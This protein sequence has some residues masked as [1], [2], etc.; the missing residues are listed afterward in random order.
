MAGSRIK[1]IT[2]EIGG[3]ATKLEKALEGVNKKVTQTSSDLKDLN[4]LLKFDPGNVELLKQKQE[5]LKKA[6]EATKERLEEEKKALAQLKEGD[7]TDEVKRNAELLERQIQDDEIALKNLKKEMKD[8]GSV[9]QQQIKAAGEKMQELGGNISKVGQGIAD[10]GTGLTTHVTAP[11]VA[12]FTAAVKTTADFDSSMSKVAAVSGATGDDLDALRAKAKEMGEETQFS[13]SQAA[14]ALNYMAMAGWKTDD[15]LSGISG[16]M[17]LAAASGEDL[18]TTSDIVTDALTAFGMTAADSGR[19]ADVLAAASSNANTNVSMLG[20]SFKYVAPVAGALG[21]SAEDTSIALGLMANA[22]IKASNAGTSLRTILTNMA[23]PTADMQ[24][25][26]E[27]L[28]VSLDDGEGN[29]LSFKAIMDQMRAGFGDMKIPLE[30]YIETEREL[31]A[32]MEEGTITESEYDKA[33]EQ[34]HIRAFGAEGAIKAQTAAMLA[35]KQGMSGLLAIVNASDED[36]AKLTEAIYNSEGA[37]SD[38]AATMNDNLNGQLKIL[39]SQIEA[40]AISIGEILIPIIRDVVTVIQE[41]VDKFN[42]LDE[43][44]QKTILT[45][46]GVVAAIGPLLLIIG[47]LVIGIGGVITAVGTITTAAAPLL[48][49]LAPIAP[50]ILGVIAAIA[51]AI[52]IGVLLYKNWD[53]I[54]EWAGKLKEKI[55]EAWDNIKEKTTELFNWVTEK[56]NAL[57]DGIS[58]AANAAKTAVTEKWNAMK[59]AVGGAMDTLKGNVENSL[60]RIKGKFEEN[61][62]GIKGAMAGAMEGIKIAMETEFNVI[63][64]LT[65]G[66]LT[67]IKDKFT[68]IFNGAK[69]IVKNALE[70]IKGFFN[71]SWELPKLKMPHPKFTGKFSLNPPQVPT[72]SIDW[73]KKAYTN[74]VMF[75]SPTVL[76][77]ASGLKGF[78]DGSGAEIVMSDRMLKQMAGTTNYNV[79]V[80]AAPGMDVRQLAD[81][82]QQRLAQVQRQ[83]EAVYA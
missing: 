59:D 11:I 8:F 55:S 4:K 74:P 34:L 52:A 54:V 80:N 51:A 72:F 42:S 22:G 44:Q 50:I 61:G 78:G 25:A 33:F 21:F 20:E 63:D 82:V 6:T 31:H 45:I 2:V 14:D 5:A 49:A 30:E 1:G 16:I 3:N 64:T 73:Y 27:A 7:Q 57:K 62:G 53:K 48:A 35:G 76:P 17:D 32:A 41:W 37:A 68:D 28:G 40:A 75:T 81:A 67:A 12:G 65:G 19:F 70:T 83:K 71:F 46:L 79:T 29:M 66:K 13:A 47:K 18:A 15:M 38:M 36:Y 26:M 39:G 56:W 10:V 77:T 58:N 24:A 60:D 43:D 69:D 23:N 9:S